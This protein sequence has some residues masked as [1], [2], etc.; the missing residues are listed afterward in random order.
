MFVIA[1]LLT[2]LSFSVTWIERRGLANIPVNHIAFPSALLPAAVY[3]VALG[4]AIA[5][6]RRLSWAALGAVI[7]ALLLVTG[8]RTNLILLIG[9]VLA[10]LATRGSI[11]A[12]IGRSLVAVIL[13]AIFLAI[14]LAFAFALTNI[15]L[16]DIQQRFNDLTGLTNSGAVAGQSFSERS[17]QTRQAWLAFRSQ[18]LTGVGPGHAFVWL[19]IFGKPHRS[20]NIDTP[21]AILA[22]FGLVGAIATL[23]SLRCYVQAVRALRL[24]VGRAMTAA[25]PA[26][27][28]ILGLWLVVLPIF[29]DK[30]LSFGLMLLFAVALRETT[31]RTDAAPHVDPGHQ[32]AL[33]SPLTRVL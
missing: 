12:K 23:Y 32:L 27:L 22:K 25:L 19:G 33:Q 15:H 29:E 9:P 1:G 8:T 30:G 26:F 16:A 2:A 7:A 31:P 5:G 21:I 20:F 11:R 13:L 18:P 24:Q 3:A 28:G 4:R 14:F 17:E 10:A 6:P